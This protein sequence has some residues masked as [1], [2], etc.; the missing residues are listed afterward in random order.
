M[1]TTEMVSSTGN[2]ARGL[3]SGGGL[4][5]GPVAT[6]SSILK[7]II[8]QSKTAKLNNSEMEP[9]SSDI[10]MLKMPAQKTWLSL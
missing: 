4:A 5:A 9:N 10:N 7:V 1:V 8:H 6:S 2:T 3:L